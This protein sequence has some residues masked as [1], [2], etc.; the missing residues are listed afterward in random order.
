MIFT[1]GMPFGRTRREPVH[2]SCPCGELLAAEVLRIVD[3]AGDPVLAAGLRAGEPAG[4]VRCPACG[5]QSRVDAP[6][7]YLDRALRRAVLVLPEAFRVRELEE[8]AAMLLSLAGERGAAIPGYAKDFVVAFG[9]SGLR[10]ALG[11]GE[12]VREAGEA[13]EAPVAVPAPA[14]AVASEVAAALAPAL[15]D[16]ALPAAVAEG[17]R[18]TPMPLPPREGS[19]AG[20]SPGRDTTSPLREV[21]PPPREAREVRDTD[22]PTLDR[23]EALLDETG[24]GGTGPFEKVDD[25]DIME[26]SGAHLLPADERRGAAQ[27]AASRAETRKTQDSRDLTVERWIVSREPARALVER[28]RVRLLAMLAGD[29]EAYVAG[30]LAPALRL[31]R[32]PAAPLAVLSVRPDGLAGEDDDPVVVPLDPQRVDDRSVLGALALGFRLDLELYDAEYLPVVQR[33]LAAPLEENVRLVV[34]AAEEHAATLPAGQRSFEAAVA[35]WRGPGFDRLG[36]RAASLEEDSFSHLPTAATTLV[37]LTVVGFWS[38]P[39]NQEYLALE[40][41]FPLIWWKRIRTRVVQRAVELGLALP[42]P[43]A[44]VAVS[45]G[46]ARSRKELARKLAQAFAETCAHGSD[47]DAQQA[48]DNWRAIVADCEAL[49][50]ALEGRAADLAAQAVGAVAPATMVAPVLA[51]SSPAGDGSPSTAVKDREVAVARR[52]MASPVIAGEIGGESRPDPTSVAT[53]RSSCAGAPTPPP[54]ARCSA[55]SAA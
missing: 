47:L 8:R 55:P 33:S 51:A 21:A 19:G 15:A 37:A 24:D 17:S 3:A 20:R 45:E 39:A 6:V 23:R 5:R 53:P 26:G 4:H 46:L 10:R 18:V 52:A 49:G 31:H 36:R 32:T 16:A 50:V 34:G 43:L 9:A 12:P 7:F 30:G 27:S 41:A 2:Y 22:P 35:L 48:Q 54:W 44:G 42:A 29:L 11:E 40:R 28:G 25:A 1:S 13:G 14:E 38:E